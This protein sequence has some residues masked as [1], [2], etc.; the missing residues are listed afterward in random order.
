M[1]AVLDTHAVIWY[2]E[3]SPDLSTLARTRIEDAVHSGDDIYVSAISLIET[4]Y[5]VEKGRLTSTALERLQLA[6]K[7]PDSG[8]IVA[9][10]DAAVAASLQ[11]IPRDIVPDMPDRIIAATALR[12]GLPLITRDRRIQSSGISTIW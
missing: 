10:V 12:L 1:S 7:E 2:L 6:L 9:P 11:E 5:L 3:N 4:V 8:M